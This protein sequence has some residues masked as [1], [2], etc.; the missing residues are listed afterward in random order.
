V[1]ELE[2]TLRQALAESAATSAFIA[3]ALGTQATLTRA[4]NLGVASLSICLDHREATLLLVH[5]GARTSAFTMMRPVLEACIRGCWFGFAAKDQ[6]ISLLFAG[7]LSTK[8]ESMARAVSKTEPGLRALESLAATHKQRLD[9]FTHGT[10]AQLS[11][12][13]GQEEITPS[14]TAS[15]MIDVLRFV[16]SVGLVACVA[17]EKI[18]GRSTE[19]FLS[20]MQEAAS[21]QRKSCASPKPAAA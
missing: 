16:D 10:G 17:R 13:Y 18:C 19:P 21:P 2:D 4:Q 15:E 5:H 12:W 14:H 1:H 3:N 9:D 6:H 7:K 8:L 11:R 20:R